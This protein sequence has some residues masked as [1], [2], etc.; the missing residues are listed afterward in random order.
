M[1]TAAGLLTLTVLMNLIIV[2]ENRV[3]AGTGVWIAIVNVFVMLWM[4][5]SLW[6]ERRV[7]R[8]SSTC[9][10]LVKFNAPSMISEL[11]P[12]IKFGSVGIINTLVDLAIFTLL[13]A[14]GVT[15]VPAQVVSYAAGL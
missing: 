12:M 4:F 15:A 3:T 6:V 2:L 7:I 8:T 10:K 11:L 1:D 13:T 14:L 9:V 5:G